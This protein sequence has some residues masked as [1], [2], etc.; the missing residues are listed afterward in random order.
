MPKNGNNDEPNRETLGS[1]RIISKR[2][3]LELVSA[4]YSTIGRWEKVGLFPKRVKLGPN[5][6]GW[7]LTEVL[8]WIEQ[9]KK[10]RAA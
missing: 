10:S 9:K 7:V 1:A 2:E 8:E 6:V 3:L 4:A 5:R